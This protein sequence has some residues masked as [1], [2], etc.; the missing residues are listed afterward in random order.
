MRRVLSVVM[1]LVVMAFS[2][3]ALAQAG[4]PCP[5]CPPVSVEFTP[6]VQVWWE[7]LLAHLVEVV[8]SIVLIVVPVLVRA[9]IQKWGA[10][11]AAEKRLAIQRLVDGVLGGAVAYAEEQA[12]KA[13]HDGG[14]RTPGAEKLGKALEYAQTQLIQSGVSD[15]AQDEL[16][17]L[18][19][20]KLHLQ[21]AAMADAARAEQ[22]RLEL[23]EE[24]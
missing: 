7:V 12:K 18:L 22:K 19:E 14:E 23:S 16:V 8:G 2:V 5:P 15:I 10:K 20:A 1:F 11:L 6:V 3:L 9:A 4:S 24:A 13:L 21:R 17:K